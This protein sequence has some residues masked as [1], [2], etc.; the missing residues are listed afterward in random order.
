MN[1]IAAILLLAASQE[2]PLDLAEYRDRLRAIQEAL[3]RK[4]LDGVRAR[5]GELR[6]RRVRHGGAVFDADETVLGPLADGAADAGVRLRALRAQLESLDGG[7][8][9]GAPDGALLERLRLEEEEL[10]RSPDRAVG[11]PR[12]HAPEVPR[13][14]SD[15]V[16]EILEAFGKLIDRFLKWLLRL[17]FSG[18][19]GKAP[20]APSTRYLVAGLVLAVLG[21]LAVVA[22]L[23]LRRRHRGP[24]LEARSEAPARSGEDDDPLS[25]SATE[26]ERFAAELMK[27]G[28]FREAIR[29]WYHALL[30]SLFR[31]GALHY[32]KDRTNW[33]YAYALP[34][35]VGWRAGFVEAT[36]TFEQEW[37]GRRDTPAETA[38]M[39]QERARQMLDAVHEGR[40]R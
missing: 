3:D 11:G 26:W 40:A 12:L 28:R 23:A 27:S 16:L 34:S 24:E 33:E 7:A 17:F 14:L 1:A 38:E 10:A 39:Y 13:S 31:A 22:V 29:A 37:Y 9:P 5:A 32:R 18:G 21:T 6:S 19:G 25:R 15:R 36:R 30:V 4:D 20:E 8:P 35:T 2:G